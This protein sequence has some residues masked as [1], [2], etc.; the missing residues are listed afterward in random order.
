VLG[1]DSVSGFSWPPKI[2]GEKASFQVRS[3][4]ASTPSTIS[5]YIVNEIQTVI[6]RTG[7]PT[8]AHHVLMKQTGCT[9]TASQASTN[10]SAQD[11]YLVRPAS[12]RG[13]MYISF[14]RKLQPD[15]LQ[16]LINSWH[17]QP[18]WQITADNLS[19]GGLAQQRFWRV[20]N[21]TVRVPIGELRRQ[22]RPDR[23]HLSHAALQRRLL[24]ARAVDRR[25]ADLV[26]LPE[27]QAGRP[28][29]RRR[30]CAPTKADAL[31]LN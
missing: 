4:T 28:L 17:G 5:D 12:E 18:Y 25:R 26:E 8:R 20:E 16:K 21:K 2:A 6:G 13:D 19:N 29:V 7:A 23:S 31:L 3:G 11:P 10:C 1:T 22:R 30:L 15:L 24:P 14:W 9:G 27:R